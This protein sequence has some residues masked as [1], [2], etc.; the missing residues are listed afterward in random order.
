MALKF[1]ITGV[2]GDQQAALF[3][4]ACQR[5][6]VKSTY[7]TGCFLLMNT[8]AAHVSSERGLL[9][10]IAWGVDGKVDYALEGSIFVAGAAVQWLR[11]ELKMIET[12]A[13]AGTAGDSRQGFQRC[14]CRARVRRPRR[15]L[16]GHACARRHRRTDPRIEPQSHRP[17]HAGVDWF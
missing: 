5:R 3:G 17:R 15:P 1:R 8:G 7:G 11:D 2:H 10:T 12:A 16:L 4:Q 6:Q 14:L 9:T 13:Q